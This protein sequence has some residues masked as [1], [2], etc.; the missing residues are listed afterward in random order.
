MP[1]VS[2]QQTI[3]Y[4]NLDKDYATTM[5]SHKLILCLSERTC[6]TDNALSSQRY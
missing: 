4:A 1:L 3:V 6:L 2:T 5:L